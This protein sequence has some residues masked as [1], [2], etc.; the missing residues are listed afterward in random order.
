M[1]TQV[2]FTTDQDL[3]NKALEKAKNEGITLKTLL[4]YAMKGFVEGKISLGIEFAEHEPEVE[5]ITF[6]DKG[7]N[8]KAKK[9]AALLK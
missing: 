5:E 9:L 1:T 3:K 6:T 7:I 2:S 8:E 4:T